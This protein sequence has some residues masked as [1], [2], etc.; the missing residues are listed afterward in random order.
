MPPLKRPED[1]DSV[2][3]TKPYAV[4]AGWKILSKELIADCHRHGIKVFSDAL[5]SNETVEHYLKAIEWGID[6]IQTDHPLRV[7]RAIELVP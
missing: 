5:G 6:C 4:D 3:A 2:A 7:L 1:L